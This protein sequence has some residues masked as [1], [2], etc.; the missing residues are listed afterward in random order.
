[1]FLESIIAGKL[2]TA[3]PN[4]CRLG[5]NGVYGSKFVTIVVTGKEGGEIDFRAY[6]ISNQVDKSKSLIYGNSLEMYGC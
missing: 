5:S 2:Q 1:L 3:H 4:P 6:Q